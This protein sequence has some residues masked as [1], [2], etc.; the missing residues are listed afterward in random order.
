VERQ[1]FSLTDLESYDP[2]APQRHGERRFCCPICGG[3]KPLDAAHRS[4]TLNAASGLWNCKRC[5]AKG[6]LR[7]HWEE[8]SKDRRERGRRQLHRVLSQSPGREAPTP[9]MQGR[10]LRDLLPGLV[11]VAGTFGEYYLADRGIPLEIT[12]AARVR[13]HRDWFGAPAVVFAIRDRDGDLVAAQGRYLHAAPPPKTRTAGPAGKGVFATSGA[14]EAGLMILTE[15][16]LD[17]LSLAACGYPAIAT[18][19]TNMPEWLPWAC[20]FKRVMVATDA[21]QS[22]DAAAAKWEPALRS[23]GA[24]VARLRPVGGKDWNELLARDAAAL[25]DLLHAAVREAR[26]RGLKGIDSG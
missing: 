2:Q 16:P 8:R 1:V 17:A 15:A 26:G 24:T 12:T 14:F 11:K 3:D 19:G 13:Y 22:G 9:P 20:T 5:G 18:I 10:N 7:E 21:D 4:L 23:A 25:R 6:K